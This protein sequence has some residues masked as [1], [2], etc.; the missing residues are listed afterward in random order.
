M[1]HRVAAIQMNSNQDV[2][3]NLTQAEQLIQ[4]A[5]EQGAELVVL[6]E[7]FAFIGLDPTQKPVEVLGTGL[8]QHFLQQCAK[9]QAIWII[10]GTIPIKHPQDPEKVF[11]A[12]LVFNPQGQRVAEYYK[13]HLFDVELPDQKYEES[14]TFYPGEATVVFTTP[15]GEIGLAI[16]YDLRFPELFRQLQEKN[17]VLMAI[18][19][20]FTVPTGQAHWEILVRA[21]AIENQVYVIAAAQTGHHPN[22]RQTYGHSM[23]VNPWGEVLAALNQEESSVVATIDLNDLQAL[24]MRFPVLKHRKI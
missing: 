16:C 12:A 18:P 13:M 11:S 4:Q 1:I 7:N 8:I 21:R 23:I 22:Q 2:S 19:A 15:L 3:H 14:N 9:K 20:A 17:A 5:V 24:R 6:P 10:G